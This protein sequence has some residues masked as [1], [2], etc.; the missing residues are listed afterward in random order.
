[1][2]LGFPVICVD[3]TR[4]VTK[5]IKGLVLKIFVFACFYSKHFYVP[6]YQDNTKVYIQMIHIGTYIYTYIHTLVYVQTH[7][8]VLH[9]TSS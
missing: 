9:L 8:Y 4:V 3:I 2:S 1:M 6:E 7:T 5:C